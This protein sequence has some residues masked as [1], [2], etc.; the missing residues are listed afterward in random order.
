MNR[1]D[2]L[3]SVAQVL[4]FLGDVPLRTFYRWREVGTAPAGLKL[5]N[6]ELRF[7][8]SEVLT[9]LDGRREDAA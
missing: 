3:L 8:R 4:A 1:H 7:W 6:G 5:P 9:W 2:E